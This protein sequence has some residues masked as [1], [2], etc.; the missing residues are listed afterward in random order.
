[1][2]KQDNRSLSVEAQNELRLRTVQYVLSGKKQDEA[3]KAFQVHRKV[4]SRWLVT[5]HKKGFEGLQSKKK[6]RH[7]G[8]ALKPWQSAQVVRT[9]QGR[10]PDQLRLP[11]YLWTRE[12]V[13]ELIE[14]R[15]GIRR[16]VWQIGRYLSDWGFTPQKPIR[17]AFEQDPVAVKQWL[18]EEYPSIRRQ[19]KLD[20]ALIFWEDE[21]GLRSDHSAGRSYGFKGKTPVIL[22]TGQR[23]R[24]NMISAI[25][26]Q[27]QLCF[28]VFRD[29]FTAEIFITFLKRL[30]RHNKRR[31]YLIIDKHPVHRSSKVTKWLKE[32]QNINRIRVFFLPIYSPELNPDELLNQDVKTNALGR[33]RPHV[34]SAM[35]GT[36]RR[37]LWKRQRQPS[38]VMN[39][40]QEEHVRYASY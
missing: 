12:A 6:G 4:V 10:C 2:T 31:L 29:R 23:F 30:I 8:G 22:G 34:Q 16:S 35:M 17:K 18:E 3:A 20:K 38:A 1:M 32:E 5:Y 11:F 28:M 33:Q 37:Y 13:A 26:N 19:A 36:V 25:A 7:K 14:R 39:Y 15:F 24:C 21:M 27:G 9:I 40:F